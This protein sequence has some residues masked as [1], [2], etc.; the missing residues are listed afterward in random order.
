ML[1]PTVAFAIFF[2]C[3]F[4]ANWVLPSVLLIV[5]FATMSE[6]AQLQVEGRNAGLGDWVADL[7]G[8]FLGLALA[9]RLGPPAIDWLVG[10]PARNTHTT[11]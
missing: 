10:R 1:F 3:V 11:R 5:A 7:A 6:I 9:S 8:T 4:T 2:V